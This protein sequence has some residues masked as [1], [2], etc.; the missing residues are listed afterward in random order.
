VFEG[1]YKVVLGQK[2]SE[3]SYF[4]TTESNYIYLTTKKI[5]VFNHI[6]E[7]KIQI[8]IIISL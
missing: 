7:F 4:Y 8:Y 3:C 1:K 2:D 6:F 5:N